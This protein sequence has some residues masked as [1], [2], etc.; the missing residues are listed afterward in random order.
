MIGALDFYFT[1]FRRLRRRR[2][3]FLFTPQRDWF[4]VFLFSSSLFICLFGFHC[5]N[6]F[7]NTE[8]FARSWFHSLYLS[9]FRRYSLVFHFALQLSLTSAVR[10]IPT[11]NRLTN[12]QWFASTVEAFNI[13]QPSLSSPLTVRVVS[14]RIVHLQLQF[15]LNR[16]HSLGFTH[17]KIIDTFARTVTLKI[18]VNK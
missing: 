4:Q 7:N 1:S 16:W 14:I 13:D 6:S 17:P 5:W 3:V 12:W 11:T 2:G 9:P 10:A 18:V 15:W 8:L